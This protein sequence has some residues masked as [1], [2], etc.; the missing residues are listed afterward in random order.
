ME[1][2]S[3]FTA[4]IR[5][6]YDR[7][8]YKGI[9]REW[10]GGKT[11]LYT[12]LMVL[13][14]TIPTVISVQ[15]HWNKFVEETG[16]EYID[17]VPDI[18]ITNG[19]VSTSAELPYVV[20][21]DETF[22]FVIDTSG[23]YDVKTVEVGNFILLKNDWISVREAD[24]SIEEYPLADVGDFSI[25]SAQIHKWVDIINK[26]VAPVVLVIMF[27]SVLF[28][29]FLRALFFTGIGFIIVSV[30]GNKVPFGRVYKVA[31]AAGMPTLMLSTVLNLTG[32][33][34][35]GSGFLLFFV[36]CAFIGLA[37]TSI[38]NPEENGDDIAN[39]PHYF[40]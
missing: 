17:K 4:I 7:S 26:F 10:G 39:M 6:F 29:Q 34:F 5:V 32:L 28:W 13:L 11:F 24:G 23:Q 25:T 9:A 12:A 27:C 15:Y 14:V 36:S 38:D 1:N 16:A 40:S 37:V 18:T 2:P 30:R 3:I 19:K 21:L 20:E 31:I 22:T 33:S 35:F 8:L